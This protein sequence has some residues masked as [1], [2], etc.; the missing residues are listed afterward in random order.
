MMMMTYLQVVNFGSVVCVFC[1]FL[2]S[3]FS[4]IRTVSRNKAYQNLITPPSLPIHAYAQKKKTIKTL[5]ASV[6]I[7][8]CIYSVS[9]MHRTVTALSGAST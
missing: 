8:L 4:C 1:L 7:A 9:S 3:H 2:L 5:A 6:R